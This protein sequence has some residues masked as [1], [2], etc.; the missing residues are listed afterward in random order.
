MVMVEIEILD[1]EPYI[2][3]IDEKVSRPMVLV[4]FRI[5]NSQVDSIAIAADKWKQA[6]QDVVLKQAIDAQ[7][8][9]G[10]KILN[11]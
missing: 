10:R 1:E 5:A 9:T 8:K 3:K 4:T 11:V 2:D 7:A 6:N